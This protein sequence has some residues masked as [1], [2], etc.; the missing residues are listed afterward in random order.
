MTSAG[1]SPSRATDFSIVIAV[2]PCV[3]SPADTTTCALFAK[4][5]LTPS[6]SRVFDEELSHPIDEFSLEFLIQ[7]FDRQSRATR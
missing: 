1:V 5:P 6:T 7:A 2:S 3:L 4:R